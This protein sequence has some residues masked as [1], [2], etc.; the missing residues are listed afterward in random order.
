MA[1]RRFRLENEWSTRRVAKSSR[2]GLDGL[3]NARAVPVGDPFWSSSS[4]FGSGHKAKYGT[5]PGARPTLTR[6]DGGHGFGT[7]VARLHGSKPCRAC[8]SGTTATLLSPS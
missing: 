2:I 7:G 4:P 3:L 6:P 1:L 8:A 5:T